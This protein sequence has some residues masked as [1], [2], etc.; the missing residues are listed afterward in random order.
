MKRNIDQQQYNKLVA[1]ICQ[2]IAKSEWRPNYVVGITR[3]GAIAAVM[4]SHY[5][6]I[7]MHALKVSLRRGKEDCES[8]LWMSEEA[9]GYDSLDSAPGS[10]NPELRSN[11]LIVDDI[12]DSGATFNWIIEDWQSNC[13]PNAPEWNNCIWNQNVKFAVLVDNQA[14][15]CNVAIDY[16]G[17]EI[18]KAEHDEW[19]VFPYEDWWR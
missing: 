16:V 7:P 10:S 14:S 8:N 3:G 1:N 12:N 18:N 6:D 11:I 17:M 5:F 19:I 9:F 15:N 13:L 2:Q 4:I